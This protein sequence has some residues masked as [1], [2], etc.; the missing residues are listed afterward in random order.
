M[1][2]NAPLPVTDPANAFAVCFM[3]CPVPVIDPAKDFAIDLDNAPAAVLL[4]DRDLPV[5]FVSAP[6]AVLLPASALPVRFAS[7]P[8]GVREPD[9]DWVYAVPPA[10]ADTHI[11]RVGA[12]NICQGFTDSEY[13][14]V[15]DSFPAKACAVIIL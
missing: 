12:L 11:L 9:I 14:S 8:A 6:V 13:I 3:S 7:A 10:A 5:R 2:D 1:V 15:L 4:P